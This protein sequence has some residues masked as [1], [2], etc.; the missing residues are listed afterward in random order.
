METPCVRAAPS[1]VSSA[2][3]RCACSVKFNFGL[4][5]TKH[6][7]TCENTVASAPTTRVA[8]A[9]V[10]AAQPTTVTSSTR[11][12]REGSN[13]LMARSGQS[14][15]PDGLV[16]PLR[17]LVDA[18]LGRAQRPQPNQRLDPT[19]SQK[20]LASG[21]PCLYVAAGR[22]L[23][24][25][26]PASCTFVPLGPT[27]LRRTPLDRQ[28]RTSNVNATGIDVKLRQQLL[29]AWHALPTGMRSEPATDTELAAFETRFGPIPAD[30]RWFLR[31]LG[32]GVV[33]AEWLDD[34]R[35][36]A[37]SYAKLAD[38]QSYWQLSDSFVVGWDGAGNPIAL[39][40]R[41]GELV[42][43]D[44]NTGQRHKLA[45]SLRDFLAQGILET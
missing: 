25:D 36:L 45:S 38:E 34:I 16:Q 13:R 2:S 31:G 33:G 30:F 9:G 20:R 41:T 39:V 11:E 12:G 3:A 4:G 22:R 43:A 35:Q 26:H 5:G 29:A 10:L 19:W 8:D 18:G 14:T 27:R 37:Q 15:W 1:Q 23:F 32:G 42:V 40:H 7:G 17:R 6:T 21:A 44:H 24:S 28:P